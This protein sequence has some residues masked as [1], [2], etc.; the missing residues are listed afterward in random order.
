MSNKN[1]INKIAE[2]IKDDELGVGSID[3]EKILPTPEEL[4]LESGSLSFNGE[5]LYKE[6][7]REKGY[8]TVNLMVITDV[9]QL[10]SEEED[11]EYLA[12][13]RKTGRA[14]AEYYNW[15]VIQC[16]K[17]GAMRTIED[18]HN[19]IYTAVKK[20]LEA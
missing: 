16:V 8:N 5:K 2:E 10:P 19:E 1:L 7:L 13:C 11:M 6:Y 3:F 9:S 4:N 20:C 12:T 17:D 14:A 18:I 15:T